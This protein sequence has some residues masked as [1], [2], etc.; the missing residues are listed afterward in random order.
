[1]GL[2]AFV[3]KTCI[4]TACLMKY[5]ALRKFIEV[6]SAR[7]FGVFDRIGQHYF[8]H[9]TRTNEKEK[10]I[11]RQEAHKEGSWAEKRRYEVS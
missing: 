11:E 8:T 6:V 10:G 7:L 3:W 5:G 4:D 2:N 9:G 1:M